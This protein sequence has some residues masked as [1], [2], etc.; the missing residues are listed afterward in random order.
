MDAQRAEQQFNISP[1]ASSRT[2]RLVRRARQHNARMEV[3]SKLHELVVANAKLQQ[4]LLSW[5]AWYYGCSGSSDKIQA[6]TC[7][8]MASIAPVIQEHV[9]AAAQGR[10]PRVPRAMRLRR[11]VS[12]H[13]FSEQVYGASDAELR[14]MQ[15]G[16]C[17]AVSK[18]AE[19]GDP[20]ADGHEPPPP[21][22][23][24]LPSPGSISQPP[25]EAVAMSSLGS[26]SPPM[27]PTSAPAADLDAVCARLRQVVPQM[28][29]NDE[30]Q[31]LS[32]HGE[33][34]DIAIQ[35]VPAL[36]AGS[37]SLSRYREPIP[38]Q[39]KRLDDLSTHTL[40]DMLQAPHWAMYRSTDTPGIT[41]VR[42]LRLGFGQLQDQVRVLFPGELVDYRSGSWV[43]LFKVVAQPAMER[44]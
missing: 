9:S 6:D 42:I 28:H 24:E 22:V 21:T 25:D 20:I 5:E 26:L 43:P 23:P 40:A 10:A 2:L 39:W 4:Q 34:H 44:A 13:V 18:S 3:E 11:N 29:N 16:S 36:P 15:R 8:R 19:A 33:S 38:D 12:S 7:A 1:M 27:G 14:R 31:P 17:S 30:N 35:A 37:P 41:N 32:C